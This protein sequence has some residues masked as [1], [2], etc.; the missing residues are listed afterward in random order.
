MLVSIIIPAFNEERLLGGTLSAVKAAAEP[1]FTGNQWQYEIIV[2][3]NNSTDKTAQIA[4]AAGAQVVFEPKNQIGR[5]RNCGAAA[6]KGNWLIFIDADSQPNVE[7]FRDVTTAIASSRA[8]AGGSTVRLDIRHPAGAFIV[9]LWNG[10]SRGFRMLA[11]SFIFCEASAF[12]QVGGFSTELYV[13]EE[14]DLTLKLKRLAR[15]RG[16][17]LVILHRHPLVTSGRKMHLYTSL[18][19]G[20]FLLKAV[21][22]GRR[23]L[24]NRETCH[25]WYDGRR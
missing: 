16:K 25:T 2:C 1:V 7:L 17:K 24:T 21:F 19:H 6:A 8:L 3:D 22:G 13:A 4:S 14:L 9:S 11:G 20:R 23:V 12:R 18:E 5:A 10:I 15:A